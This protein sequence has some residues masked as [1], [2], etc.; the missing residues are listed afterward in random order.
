MKEKAANFMKWILAGALVGLVSSLLRYLEMNLDL[1][2]QLKKGPGVTYL[3]VLM[4]TALGIKYLSDRFPMIRGSGVPQL[5]GVQVNR[6]KLN[7]KVE[8]PLKFVSVT[9]LNGL[10]LSIG[11][12]GPSVQIGAYLG[13]AVLGGRKDNNLLIICGVA[14]LSVFL[15][16]PMAAVALAHEEFKLSLEWNQLVRL[17]AVILSAWWI[18][19][20]FFGLKPLLN[21]PVTVFPK[22]SGVMVLLVFSIVLGLT[23]KVLLRWVGKQ[24]KW[25]PLI[26]LPFLLTFYFNVRMPQILGGGIQVFDELEKQGSELVLGAV[27][28]I[29][30]FKLLLTLVCAGSGIPA[31]LFLPVL[32]LGGTLGCVAAIVSFQWMGEFHAALNAYIIMGIGLL[33]ASVMRLPVTATLLAVELTGGYALAPYL[34]LLTLGLDLFL[35]KLGDRPLNEVL[36]EK[37]LDQD[38][39]IDY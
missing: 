23:F 5:K 29:L 15:G 12:A 1:F 37:L 34:G 27:I 6:L 19:I 31:G 38:T 18:R 4:L 2:A 36:L 9:V 21:F 13:Q 14:S 8:L 11:S 39:T 16:V 24:F 30:I 20:S 17:M 7:P 32:S 25:K 3:F 26:L 10:G 28:L 22:V 35:K 33:F